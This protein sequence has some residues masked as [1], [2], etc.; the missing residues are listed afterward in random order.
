MQADQPFQVGD[1]VSISNRGTGVVESVSWRGVKIRTFQ[2]KLLIISN[3]VLGKELI[4]VAS[5]GRLNARVVAFSTVYSSSPAKTAQVAR[6][7]IRLA[8]NLSP[9]MRPNVRIKNLGDSGIEWEV[10]YWLENYAKYNDTDALVRQRLWYAF[11]REK[12]EFSY[13]TRTIQIEAK[14]EEK[15]IEE[16]VNS[17]TERLNSVSIF[18]PLSDEETERLAHSSTIRVYAPGEA[19]VR[20]GQEGRSMF[21]IM[22][23]SVEVQVPQGGTTKVLNTL[24]EN[25][26]FGEMSL[27]TG[28][29]RTATVVAIEETEVLQIRKVAIKPIFEANPELVRSISEMVEERREVLRSFA[30]DESEEEEFREKGVLRSIRRFFGLK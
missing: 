2:N 25:D 5:K 14:P 18:A 3:S 30:K 12:I 23:G 27:L 29:P 15:P 10:K 7:A 6:D 19:I 16:H 11:Q 26:F 17:V 20:M 4:E 21:I 9:K 1:V 24:R 8:E 22:R 28:E 13:P